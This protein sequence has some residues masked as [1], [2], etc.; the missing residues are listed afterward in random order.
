MKKE[1]K[2]SEVYIRSDGWVFTKDGMDRLVAGG[3]KGFNRFKENIEA[4][5]GK[6]HRVLKPLDKEAA[7]ALGEIKGM[8]PRAM[9]LSSAI[10][11]EWARRSRMPPVERKVEGRA[12]FMRLTLTE[13]AYKIVCNADNPMFREFVSD[14]ICRAAGKRK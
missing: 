14:A 1:Q 5:I 2:K 12:K 11:K 13:D 7:E 10:T 3:H 4:K 9:F 6:W 8:I